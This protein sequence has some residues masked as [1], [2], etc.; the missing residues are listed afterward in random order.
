MTCPIFRDY[1][2][3]VLPQRKK[4][5]VRGHVS[6]G[7]RFHLH[8]WR[9]DFARL[10][11]NEITPKMIREWLAVMQAKKADDTRGDRL[12]STQTVARA[13]ALVSAILARAVEHELIDVNPCRD[14]KLRKRAEEMT[15]SEP[16]TW[17]TIEEQR[18]FANCES[19]PVW[20]RIAIRF[21]CATGLRQGEQF[22][23]ELQDVHVDGDKPHVVVRY[24]S[25]KKLPP[26][27]GKIRRVPLFGDG[28]ASAREAIAYVADR[29]NPEGLLFPSAAGTRRGIG[30]PLGRVRDENGVWIDGW[31]LAKRNV[32]LTRRV[33]WHD[34]RHSAASLLLSGELGRRWTLDEIRPF[35]GHS[36][37]SVTAR[38]AHLG[39][40]ELA[41]C[42]RETPGTR[43][44]DQPI[45]YVPTDLLPKAIDMHLLAEMIA[46]RV[47]STARGEEAIVASEALIPNAEDTMRDLG[48]LD[49]DVAEAS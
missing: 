10:P 48:V 36:S 33:R 29:P 20:D 19:I 35:L 4:E 15:V 25:A 3:E 43:K 38:Y 18:A 45:D 23:L 46:A 13:K 39:E 16:W 9:A 47:Q 17:L 1:A 26:K 21:A 14:V 24:G 42:A 7:S 30:K 6:E 32:G 8:V 27:N 28:L 2:I 31:K 34:C 22:A 12:L 49:D 41:R 44:A 37:P 5:G 11:L 40:D